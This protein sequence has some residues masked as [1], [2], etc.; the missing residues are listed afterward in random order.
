MLNMKFV[1]LIVVVGL[2]SLGCVSPQQTSE[3]PNMTEQLQNMTPE[4]EEQIVSPSQPQETQPQET[5]QPE[6]PPIQQPKN[7]TVWLVDYSITPKNVSIGVG[8]TVS[9][10]HYQ[11]SGNPVFVL[12][13]DEGLWQP[14][15]MDY[16][17]IFSYTF[18]QK[19]VYHFHVEG[20]EKIMSGTIVVT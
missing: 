12:V 18:T 20:F 17:D 3:Q 1:I 4:S 9:F 2:L 14:Q 6:Q 16:G 15:R 19:G 11:S 5:L 7:I 13:S 10:V 8:G